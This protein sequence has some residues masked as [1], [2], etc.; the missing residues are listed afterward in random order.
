[1]IL[2]RL[3]RWSEDIERWTAQGHCCSKTPR[4]GL[5]ASLPGAA[6]R[7]S[8]HNICRLGPGL[9]TRRQQSL[10]REGTFE[11]SIGQA[12][13]NFRSWA[14]VDAGHEVQVPQREVSGSNRPAGP[15]EYPVWAKLRGSLVTGAALL[16]VLFR[17][18]SC[19]AECWPPFLTRAE[20]RNVGSW[21]GWRWMACSYW[22]MI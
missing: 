5:F 20:R 3:G 21:K 16:I 14:L 11:S 13:V 4:T 18:A 10:V 15:H 2:E 7:R 8:Q 17:P 19:K 6:C 9:P 1:M 12:I 22:W